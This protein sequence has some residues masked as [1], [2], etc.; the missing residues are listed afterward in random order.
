MVD[1]NYIKKRRKELKINQEKMA[2]SLAVG[3]A[4]A[5]GHYETGRTE[6]KASHLPLL[7]EV[8]NCGIDDLFQEGY[9][10]EDKS[11]EA[12]IKEIKKRW[13]E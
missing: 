5:Y 11:V 7:C 12:L 2:A 9:L 4:A 13:N 8:L 3:S 10:P 6:F 1:L